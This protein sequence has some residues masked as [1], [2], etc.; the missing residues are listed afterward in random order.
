MWTLES[1]E[2]ALAGLSSGSGFMR[3]D[4]LALAAETIGFGQAE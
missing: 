1:V 3:E 4:T 2:A